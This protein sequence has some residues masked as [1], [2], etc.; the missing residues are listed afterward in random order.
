MDMQKYYAQLV[1]FKIVGFKFDQDEWVR[2]PFPTFILERG[3]ERVELSLSIDAEGNNGGF[4]F[5][6]EAA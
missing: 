4:G 3:G 2:D 5:I 6:Q 1:G